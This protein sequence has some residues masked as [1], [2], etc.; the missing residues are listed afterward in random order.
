MD[1]NLY[2]N[3]V[4]LGN[5]AILITDI[6]GIILFFNEKAK[7]LF[8]IED[9]FLLLFDLLDNSTKENLRTAINEVRESKELK[10]VNINYLNIKINKKFNFE[11][12]IFVVD[13]PEYSQVLIFEFNRNNS[14]IPN[15]KESID[16][17]SP[18]FIE[19]FLQLSKDFIFLIDELG[20]IQ[21]V[22]ESFS[23]QLNMSKED[24]LYGQIFNYFEINDKEFIENFIKNDI[25]DVSEI[26]YSNIK[27]D[28]KVK[29]KYRIY[30]SYKSNNQLTS[31]LILLHCIP[32]ELYYKTMETQKKVVD[33]DFLGNVLHDI[34]TP[35]N[36]ILGFSR[37]LYETIQN[38]S[39]E[40][41][42]NYEIIEQNSQ[43]LHKILLTFAEFISLLENDGQVMLSKFKF[44]DIY[45]E[46]E[47]EIT[48][49]SLKYE[50][51]IN[52]SKMATNIL[53]ESDSEK[54]I[55]LIKYFLNISVVPFK[56]QIL[57]FSA[58]KHDGNFLVTL[59]DDFSKASKKFISIL[60]S[61]FVKKD[62]KL[63]KELGI[64]KLQVSV[65]PKLME[66]LGVE[67][68]NNENEFGIMIPLEYKPQENIELKE[69]NKTN[70]NELT[71]EE[72][73][74]KTTVSEAIKEIDVISKKYEEL[75]CIYIED[76]VDSQILFKSQ[77][78]ELKKVDFS[79][80]F[81]EALPMIK[82]FKYDFIV[83]DINLEGEYNGIDAMKIIRNTK[84]YENSLIVGATAFLMPGD[85]EKFLKAG[86]NEFMPKP[87][88]KEKL[89]PILKNFFK[90]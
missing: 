56:K 3:L 86:F 4:N 53:I 89:Y 78:N 13:D 88:T 17:Y 75:C 33:I 90:F 64:S 40:Q 55:S 32:L 63:R 11:V 84:G 70:V 7:E 73:D 62:D 52:F 2:K 23:E 87:V 37:E 25:N 59:K 34:N 47:Q 35:I 57:F 68:L 69:N 85:K 42:E 6:S 74:K 58:Y 24:I 65:L 72:E 51:D 44:L 45:P 61:I 31:N 10:V 41:R 22:S 83:L 19:N 43:Y 66:F 5:N 20:F 28:R 15:I 71:Y 12:K 16:D 77:F 1:S 21:N 48:N 60:D 27:L 29:I 14:V 79:T 46:I 36:A 50:V 76:Q 9:E 81:E 18:T 82:S 54:L 39:D 80:S 30:K 38:P 26:Q 67:Y 8:N 49:L